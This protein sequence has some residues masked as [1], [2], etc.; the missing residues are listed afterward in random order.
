MS[1]PYV[2]LLVVLSIPFFFF[3]NLKFDVCSYSN[4]GKFVGK[5]TTIIFWFIV[6]PQPT[7]FQFLI[8]KVIF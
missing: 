5:K 4:C 7:Y 2:Q 1:C 8:Q 6:R 3:T